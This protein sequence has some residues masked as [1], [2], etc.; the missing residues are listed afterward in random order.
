MVGCFKDEIYQTKIIFY[1]YDQVESG[2]DYFAIDG[3]VAHS[4]AADTTDYM[5]ANYDDALA[6]V[7]THRETGEQIFA[8]TT[9]QVDPQEGF[10][11]AISL[12]AAGEQI[13][14][15]AVDPPN[16]QYAYRN[17]SMGLNLATTYIS[18]IFRG[19]KT[20][21]FVQSNWQFIID[22]NMV[23]V[24]EEETE[25]EEETTDEELTEEETTEEE[26]T[27]DEEITDEELTDN[28]ETTTEEN[29]NESEVETETEVETESEVE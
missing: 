17:Y 15:V 13:V 8:T 20:E 1:C 25:D 29:E 28:E 22:E 12:D 21:D 24:E 3:V 23:I 7:L 27:E 11:S 4:F 16:I 2:G 14:L 26:L 10:G 18:I 5:V 19:W 6:G 9:S